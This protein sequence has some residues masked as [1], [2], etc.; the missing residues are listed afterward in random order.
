MQV[1]RVDGTSTRYAIARRYMIRLRR[2]DLQ[3]GESL[4]KL[5]KVA[6]ITPE[7]FKE[8]FGPIVVD[9]PPSLHIPI[10]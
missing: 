7:A 10:K 1:R 6:G 2:D 5:A 8:R 9:E 3:D 4:A